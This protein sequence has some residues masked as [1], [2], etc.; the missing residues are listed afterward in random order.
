MNK[1]DCNH[2]FERTHKV[3]DIYFCN[4]CKHRIKKEEIDYG[5]KN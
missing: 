3:D 5:K 4:K 2:P 1:K